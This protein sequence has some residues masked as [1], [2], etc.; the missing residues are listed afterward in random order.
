MAE[1]TEELLRKLLDQK[2]ADQFRELNKQLLA[3]NR[4]LTKQVQALTEQ[5]AYLTRKLFGTHSEKLTDP[6]QLSLLED[7]GVFTD[8]EQTGN[9]SEE[10]VVTLAKRKPRKKREET[11]DPKLPVRETL[12]EPDRNHCE[13]GHALTKVGK[14]FVR[15]VVHYKPGYLFVERIYEARYKCAN[16]E[17]TDGE[18]HLY[19]GNAPLALFSHSL[20]TPSLGTAV[21]HPKYTLGT[22]VYRQRLEWQRAGLTLSE[23]TMANWVSKAADLVRPVY[24]LIHTRLMAHK[25]LQGDETPFQVLREPGK[26]PRSKSYIWVARTTRLAEHPMTY[27]AYGNNRSGKFA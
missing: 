19:Q 5:V 9:Q 13:H 22:P 1:T 2:Q 10:T 6:N 14:H 20:A 7:E 8:P 15:D 11:I 24:D 26:T 4:D 27:Y 18:T 23:T 3:Q 17:R 12:I 21:L 16:C 25:F